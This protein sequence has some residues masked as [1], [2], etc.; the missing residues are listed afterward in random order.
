MLVRELMIPKP[1]VLR[2]NLPLPEALALMKEKNAHRMPVVDARGQV[3]GIV[4][5]TDLHNAV[6]SP[7]TTLS[8]WEIPEL[9]NRIKV[10]DL[11]VKD[12]ATIQVDAQVE[13]AARIMA[14]RDVSCLPVMDG[15]TLVG[16]VNQSDV[17]RAFMELLG[18]RRKGVRVWATTPDQKG[19]IARMTTAIAEASGNIVG[20]GF[21][22]VS[23]AKGVRWEVTLKV[24][25]VPKDK[26]VDLLKPHVIEFLDV[27]E[28]E[29]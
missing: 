1:P 22:E 23:D 6:P 14:D 21:V 9:L 24:Q 18:G 17:F 8:I 26:L 13:E 12:V 3:V 5:E 7:A 25:D 16:L 15:R 28:S 11:M 27:R 29:M 2:P 19:T 10:E 20:L 4:S